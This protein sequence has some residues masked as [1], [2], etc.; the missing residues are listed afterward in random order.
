MGDGEW[1]NR[2]ALAPTD[3]SSL[4]TFH[5]L[6]GIRAVDQ[7]EIADVDDGADALSGNEDRIFP[8]DR[9]GQRD[10][11]S[12]EAQVPERDRHL[13]GRTAFRGEPLDNP[14]AEEQTLAEKSRGNPDGVGC[15]HNAVTCDEWRVTGFRF[16]D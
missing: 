5:G 1:V 15:N 11:A 8:V 2:V 13:A 14:A 3:H 10:E 6:R 9:I 16:T 7:H 4:I 12:D